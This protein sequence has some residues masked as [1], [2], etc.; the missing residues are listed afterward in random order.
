MS[1]Q[2]WDTVWC[3]FRNALH[4]AYREIRHLGLP[5]DPGAKGHPPPSYHK[6]AQKCRANRERLKSTVAFRSVSSPS[7]ADYIQAYEDLTDL[8]PRDLCL[9]FEKAKWERGYGGE[10]WAVITDT[11]IQ[12]AHAIDADDLAACQPLLRV[13]RDLHHNSGPLVPTR[14]KW[15]AFRWQQEKWPELCDDE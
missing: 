14:R 1:E 12:L 9:L 10:R 5:G 8:N 6:Q 2:S 7:T 3:Y 15:K 11:V 13:L 4:S